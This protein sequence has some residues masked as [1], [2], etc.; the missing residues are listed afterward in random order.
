MSYLG[1]AIYE[2]I[3]AVE[4]DCYPSVAPN[5]ATEP[6]VVYTIISNVP[7]DTKQGIS[8]LDIIRVQIDIYADEYE[9]AHT[10]AASVRSAMDRRKGT[11]RGNIIDNIIFDGESDMKESEAELYRVTQD[12][13]VRLRY[14]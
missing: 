10:L 1:K 5:D 6:Y 11:I 4:A 9:D 12:Y 3:K 8:E 2:I 13:F 7:E 14:T